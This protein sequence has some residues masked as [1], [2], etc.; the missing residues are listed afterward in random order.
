MMQPTH[1]KFGIAWGL[2]AI[3]IAVFLGIVP[4]LGE[5]FRYED[6]IY[7]LIG[8]YAAMK[9]AIF[10]SEMP[11]TDHPTSIPAR[12]HPIL[13]QYFELGRKITK[14]DG[15]G[16]GPKKK[17]YAHRGIMSHDYI[18]HLIQWSL[19]YMLV[20]FL[21]GY[22]MV[23]IAEGNS[24]ITVLI[25]LAIIVIL[26]SFTGDL[27]HL[28]HYVLNKSGVKVKENILVRLGIFVLAMVVVLSVLSKNFG[29]TIMDIATFNLDLGTSSLIAMWFFYAVKI[30]IIFTFVG[31]VSHL[32]GDMITVSGVYL[33]TIRIQPMGMFKILTKIP[34]LNLAFDGF[35]TGG[36]W[37][38]INNT[39]ITII[40]FPATI[41]AIMT[42]FGWDISNL[43]T[44]PEV[45]SNL[46]E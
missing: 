11:D 13:S 22:T 42:V 25:Y 30:F 28:T 14:E 6:V 34:G 17:W 3:P 27:H 10:G 38:K 36:P 32:F 9:G 33:G 45:F 21:S 39:I 4:S 24:M 12:K 5:D 20:T 26:W 1:L 18:V 19:L 41:L 29:G 37:E 2:L 43:V 16:K 7:I 40:I 23:Q 8:L 35:R 31:C 15:S 46:G 44:I